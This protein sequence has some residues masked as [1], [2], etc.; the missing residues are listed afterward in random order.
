MK[1]TDHPLVGKFVM[2]NL[3]RI[4]S[5]RSGSYGGIVRSVT[6]S[7]KGVLKAARVQLAGGPKVIDGTTLSSRYRG[8]KL[9]L[10]QRELE[11]ARVIIRGKPHPVPEYKS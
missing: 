3:L 7:A 9:T 10:D 5:G 8:E 2:F 4:E 6:L 1:T 11:K